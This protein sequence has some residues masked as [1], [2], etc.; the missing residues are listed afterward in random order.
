VSVY[1][2]FALVVVGTAIGAAVLYGFDL[3]LRA[4][5]GE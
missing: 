2:A 3:I 1:E 4:L 5:F